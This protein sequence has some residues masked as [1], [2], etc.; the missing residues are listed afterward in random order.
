LRVA[1]GC[2]ACVVCVGRFRLVGGVQAQA[3]VPR[4]R[5]KRGERIVGWRVVGCDCTH[6]CPRTLIHTPA[7]ARVITQTD[8]PLCYP[9]GAE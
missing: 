6:S 3:C 9:R 7:S 1:G 5:T 4:A 8:S 2:C